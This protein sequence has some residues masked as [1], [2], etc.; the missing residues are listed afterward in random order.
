[1]A[2]FVELKRQLRCSNP[3]PQPFNIKIILDHEEVEGHK[4]ILVAESKFFEKLFT[5]DPR[6]WQFIGK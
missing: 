4:N 3:P 2:H 5:H 1:M 6:D